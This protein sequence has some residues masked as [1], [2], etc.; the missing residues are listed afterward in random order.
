MHFCLYQIEIHTL[1]CNTIIKL[2]RIIQD[3]CLVGRPWG[4]EAHM[5]SQGTK[6]RPSFGIWARILTQNRVVSHWVLDMKEMDLCWESGIYS[7]S[8][9]QSLW[10][11]ASGL[12]FIVTQIDHLLPKQ[13]FSAVTPQVFTFQRSRSSLFVIK[14]GPELLQCVS[15]DFCGWCGVRRFR[16]SESLSACSARR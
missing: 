2:S 11:L 13:T 4:L 8:Q 12:K 1:C 5:F 9:I 15:R 3:H 16:L 6:F 7:S 14:S 10:E